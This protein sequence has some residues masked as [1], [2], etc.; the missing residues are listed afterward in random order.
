[1]GAGQDA[2]ADVSSAESVALILPRSN[3]DRSI[4]DQSV[5]GLSRT[6]RGICAHHPAG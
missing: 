2:S 5:A 3:T 4:C 1:M 6:Y